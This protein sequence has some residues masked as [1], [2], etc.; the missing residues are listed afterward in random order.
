MGHPRSSNSLLDGARSGVD[1]TSHSG[2]I[3]EELDESTWTPRPIAAAQRSKPTPETRP[4]NLDGWSGASIP[5]LV[6]L[7]S[8]GGWIISQCPGDDP[9]SGT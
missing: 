3:R 4:G 9:E 6:L 7:R 8:D 2:A 5:R 1:D